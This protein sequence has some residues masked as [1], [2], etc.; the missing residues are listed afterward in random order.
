MDLGI[1]WEMG[2]G[3]SS[4]WPP[5]MTRLSTHTWVESFAPVRQVRPPNSGGLPIEHPTK[6]EL[7][8]N[9]KTAKALGLNIPPS[10][11]LRADEARVRHEPRR[12]I[13]G[14][15]SSGLRFEKAK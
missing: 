10:L 2:I 3:L 6:F 13:M 4:P 14:E 7:V 8:I 12:S 1:S 5:I 9:L 15:P 11:L